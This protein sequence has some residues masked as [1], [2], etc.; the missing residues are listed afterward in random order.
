MDDSIL[1]RVMLTPEGLGHAE[2]G[3]YQFIL[4]L[5]GPGLAGYAEFGPYQL[6]KLRS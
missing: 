4:T 6:V 5:D 3:P 1:H 2:F